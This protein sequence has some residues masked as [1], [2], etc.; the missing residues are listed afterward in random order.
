MNN[1]ECDYLVSALK[2]QLDEDESISINQ[3]CD[4]FS[5]QHPLFQEIDE[6]LCK[7]VAIDSSYA[8]PLHGHYCDAKGSQAS[9]DLHDLPSTINSDTLRGHRAY[10]VTLYLNDVASGGE[11]QFSEA[12]L[13]I[14]PKAGLAMIWSNLDPGWAAC[15]KES[16]TVYARCCGS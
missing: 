16:W 1:E 9:V 8:E 11:T 10:A 3:N 6:R 14:K 7:L 12:N 15:S 4:F 5:D 13:S 2:E